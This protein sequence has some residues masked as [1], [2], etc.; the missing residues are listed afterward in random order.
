MTTCSL[1]FPPQ[2]NL[3][4]LPT[5]MQPLRRFSEKLGVE[6]YIKRDDLTGAALSGNKIRKLEFVLADALGQQ[7]D[8]VITCGG[9]QSNHCRATAIAAAM[10]GL[11]CRLLLRTPDPSNPPAPEGNILLD[12]MA[13]A[14]IIWI[15]P[16][17]YQNRDEL[18]A[19]DA[20][21]MKASG[22]KAY[23]I[24]EGASTALGTLGY[25]RA[26]EELVNDITNTMGGAHQSC[27]IISATASGGTTAGLILGAKIFDMNARIAGV[28][29]C[30]D[31]DYFIDEIGTICENAIAEFHLDIDF[32]RERDIDIIDGYVGHGYGLSRP[33]ELALLKEVAQTEGIFLDPVYTGKAFFGIVEELKRDPKCFGERV[34]FIHTGGIFGLF[35][36]AQELAEL[37]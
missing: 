32:A 18:M 24:P 23:T 20:D 13:G 10:L 27:T 36:K 15:T 5:P 9:A 1:S 37:L 6:L 35:P 8:T 22:R 30:D 29:V 19:R 25:V 14:E 16:E 34:I 28:N 11:R 7:A 26:A 17:Q 33:V 12:R 21:E 31:R 4:S 2:I 3:A